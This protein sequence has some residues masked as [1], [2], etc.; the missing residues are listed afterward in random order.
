M[1]VIS[2]A[3]LPMSINFGVR[4]FLFAIFN[5]QDLLVTDAKIHILSLFRVCNTVAFHD[6]ESPGTQRSPSLR[7]H[8][9]D[10]VWRSSAPQASLCDDA[11]AVLMA[12]WPHRS[13]GR[14]VP[15]S[16]LPL[17]PLPAIVTEGRDG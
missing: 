16:R 3:P 8:R 14:P 6:W 9:G 15:V 10:P 13:T 5:I 17:S 2:G 1:V 11:G 12:G 4:I 7:Q